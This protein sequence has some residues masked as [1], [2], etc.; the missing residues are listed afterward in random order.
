MGNYHLKLPINQIIEGDCLKILKKF[1]N[2]SI[3]MVFTSPP[4]KEKDVGS[5]YWEQYDKWFFEMKRVCKKVLI[6]IHSATKLNELISRYPPKRLLIWGKGFS[7]YSYRFNLILVYQISD[8]YKVNKY[9]WSDC[10]GIPSIQGKKR[11]HKYQ[12]PLTLYELLL[13]M[14]KDCNLILDPFIGSGTTAVA[15]KRLKRNFIG[16]DISKKYCELARQRIKNQS[17]PLL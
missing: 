10:F 6:I 11:E 15:C 17:E 7:Q 16:I 14:F 8:S 13:K 3:D 12:D 2:E 4:F 5:D 1:P 9:I